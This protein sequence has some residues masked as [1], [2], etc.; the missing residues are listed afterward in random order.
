MPSRSPNAA[1]RLLALADNALKTLAGGV[2]AARPRPLAAAAELDPAARRDAARVLRADHAAEVCSQALYQG[3]AWTA[4]DAALRAHFALAARDAC[5]H[6][7]WCDQRLR[8]LGAAPSP[9]NPLWYA[10]ALG[11]GLLAGRVAADRASLGLAVETE[12]Q[13]ERRLDADMRRLPPADSV[14]RA[15]LEQMRDDEAARARAAERLGAQPLP[16]PLRALMRAGARL[17]SAAAGA[18]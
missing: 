7:A 10:T 12:L 8:E 14:S 18:V 3:Q 9:L 17:M 16:R 5:D 11:A 2:H 4:R 15:L 1:D 6:L 13:A